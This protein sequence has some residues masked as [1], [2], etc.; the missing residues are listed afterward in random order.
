MSE[1]NVSGRSRQETPGVK[2]NQQFA[3]ERLGEPVLGRPLGDTGDYQSDVKRAVEAATAYYNTGVETM[4]DYEYD[5]LL[6][7]VASFENNYPDQTIDHELFT[8]VAAGTSDGTGDVTHDAP[9]LSLDKANTFGEVRSFLDKAADAGSA[10]RAEPKLD[11]MAIN[12]KYVD[13]KIA[14]IATRGDGRNG[15]NITDR[16]VQIAPANLPPTVEWPRTVN[17]RGELVMSK[18]DF[19][20]SNTNRTG[21]GKPAFANPRNAVAGSVRKNNPGYAV[22]LS[23]VSYGVEGGPQDPED[24]VEAGFNPSALLLDNT[25]SILDQVEAF[26]AARDSFPY[27]TDGIVLK[28]TDTDVQDT[29][30]ETSRAPR[31]AVAYKY[32]AATA[33][34]KLLG[35]ETAVGRTGAISYTAILE[36]VE[37]D[38]SVVGRATLHN[39]DNIRNK[40]LRINDIVE[41]AKMNDIIPG[42]IRSF[43]GER[44]DDSEPYVPSTLCPVSG[45]ELDMSGVI[46][47]STDPSA[48]LG[49]LVTYATSRDALDIDS[50]GGEISDA[51]VDS[52]LIQ[53]LGDLYSL[54]ETQLANLRLGSDRVVGQKTAAKIIANIEKAKAQPLNR[55]LTSLG[56]RKFGRTFG[57]RVA[58]KFHTMDAILDAPRSDF[59]TVEGVGDE[60]ADLFYQG[61]TRNRP[62]IEKMRAAGVNFGSVPVKDDGAIVGGKALNGMK[63]VV[64]GAMSGPLASMNRTQVQELIEANGGQASGSVSSS[65]NLLV[66]GEPGSSKW[67]KAQSLGVKIVTPEEFAGMLGL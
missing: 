41:I 2:G 20:F 42:V 23:F 53:D 8:A 51:L 59:Y 19:E 47:R 60:R 11:G 37:L 32:D 5:R 35:I 57:R 46:W 66:C 55:H 49:A 54:T 30:G 48:S 3:T 13:G 24:A 14:M 27:P 43:P 1:N 64:T 28:M 16:V 26:G 4:T 12:V 65:T 18:D 10:V 52:G 22:A 7:Q 40:D 63:V 9:M 56:I 39:V 33:K 45:T 62:V 50:L 25:G 36:P 21:A 58:A 31:W 67:T 15:E 6:E 29:L 17:V 61:F 44:G 38:G 34:T